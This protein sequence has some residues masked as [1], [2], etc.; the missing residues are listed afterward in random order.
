M[1]IG[2]RVDGAIAGAHFIPE[3]VVK[4]NDVPHRDVDDVEAGMRDGVT[5]FGV[6][7][8]CGDDHL[9]IDAG[10]PD[11]RVVDAVPTVDLYPVLLLDKLRRRSS[12]RV[13][14]E[15]PDVVVEDCGQ[16]TQ[17]PQRDIGLPAFH[18]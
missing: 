2:A 14:Q 1:G 3:V 13:P 6:G 18:G 16:P 17:A 10:K 12:G 5:K 8:K 9:E 4:Q 7:L 15:R 11:H